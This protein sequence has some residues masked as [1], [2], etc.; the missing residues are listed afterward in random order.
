[1]H[2]CNTVTKFPHYRSLYISDYDDQLEV[3]RLRAENSR[4]QCELDRMQRKLEQYGEDTLRGNDRLRKME[5]AKRQ[6]DHDLRHM[7]ESQGKV[8][9]G[10]NTQTEVAM[11]QFRR[12][13]E[14]LK[15]Q[16][17]AKDEIISIQE[18][19]IA[20]LVEANCTLRSGLQE[21]NSLPRHTSS[22]SDIEDE[23]EVGG[24]YA[25]RRSSGVL[26]GH[27]HA[28][29]SNATVVGPLPN[30]GSQDDPV[31]V[32]PDLLHVISQLGSGKF[33]T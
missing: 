5:E 15:K 6:S 4:L 23:L 31:G 8:F 7:R 22:D 25:G 28:I 1:M 29:H 10:L 27:T 33:D 26:N 21:L 18:K 19:K 20:S 32:N 14:N 17:L 9:R 11:V 13:F 16:L 24:E 12:D 30:Y 2:A 3:S